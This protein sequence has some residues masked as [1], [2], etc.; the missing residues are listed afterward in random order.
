MQY[1]TIAQFCTPLALGVGRAIMAV[2]F[3]T[4]SAVSVDHARIWLCKNAFPWLFVEFKYEK[5]P[6]LHVF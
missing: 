6:F 4:P 5:V 2:Q 1:L 3:C